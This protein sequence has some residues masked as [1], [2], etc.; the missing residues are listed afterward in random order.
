MYKQKEHPMKLKSALLSLIAFSVSQA[1]SEILLIN[2]RFVPER[3]GTINLFHSNG[4]FYVIQN[5]KMHTVE[6]HSVDKKIRSID[7]KKLVNFLQHGHIAINQ[8][9]HGD[10]TLRANSW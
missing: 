10:F 3:L 1:S 7:T 6:N 8:T 9:D 4:K 2:R 5:N